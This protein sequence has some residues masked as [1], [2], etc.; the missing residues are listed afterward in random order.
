MFVLYVKL[1]DNVRHV[2]T[3]AADGIL[4]GNLPLKNILSVLS[5]SL[6]ILLVLIFCGIGVVQLILGFDG[7]DYHLGSGFAWGS[8]ILAFLGFTIPITIGTYFG[9]V[10]VLGWPWW[11]GILITLPG[12]V[13][14]LPLLTVLPFM[15]D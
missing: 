8:L 5:G 1:A 12:T 9:V 13:L 7:I 14:V 11:L 6:R 10:D 15:R 3:F 4:S 2:F